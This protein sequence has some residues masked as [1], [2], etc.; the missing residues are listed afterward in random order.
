MIGRT[1]YQH[2]RREQQAFPQRNQTRRT[3]I[4]KEEDNENF[5]WINTDRIVAGNDRF[6]TG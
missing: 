4:N 6:G 3:F 1:L 5:N 2:V